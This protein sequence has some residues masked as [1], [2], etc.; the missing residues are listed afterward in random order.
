M[1]GDEEKLTIVMFPWL[2]FGHMIPNL[3]LAKLIARKGHQ[4]SFVSTP[5]NIQRLPKPSPNTLINFVK[6][7]LPKIQNLPENAEATTDIPYDVVEHLKVAYDALQ[8]PLK[9]FLESSKPDWLFYDFVPFWAG[10]IASKLGIKSAFYSICTPPFSG[11]LGPPSSLMGK[12]SL[13]Q[14]PEDFIVSPPWVPFPTTVAFRYFEIMRIVDSLSAENNTGVSDAYR[15]G[16]SAENCD[17]VVIRGCTE[18]QPEWFQVL[19]NIYRKPVLPIGQLPSTDPVGGED[20]DTWRWVKDW[21]DKHARGSVVY[22]AFGSEAK[23]R[24]DEVTEIALGLEKSKLPFF[25]ALRLQRG[26]W[27]PDVLRLPEGFEERT[28]ALGVVCTTWAPQ[29]K[30]LGHMAVGGFLT[31][32]GWTSVVEAILNEKP[33]VLLTFLSDQGIN[34]RVLEEKK[35]GYSVPRN[36]RDGLFTSDSVAE[37]LRLVMVEEE[38]RIYRERIKEMKDLFVNRERQNMYIDNLL[39]TLTSSLK[40]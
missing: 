35:M 3:E 32:S 36:E 12:D 19:E 25:W 13:R 15:Y 14:K 4:V 23:P 40:C 34:A 29:L 1:A 28:K 16:A 17:I 37:S 24:Q 33:L 18:F 11:F 5:R 2:A 31:H 8:E 20:T 21:L 9:R 22:V 6:L 10:S 38:G 26:P 7:P 27:D 30:I 39:R